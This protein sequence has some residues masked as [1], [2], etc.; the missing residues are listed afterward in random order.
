ML[1]NLHIINYRNIQQAD[2]E[3][4]GGINCFVGAN[5][6]GKTNLLDAVYY[7]SFTKSAFCLVDSQ[8]IYHGEPFFVLQG[9][10]NIDDD[11]HTIY[12]GCKRGAKKQFKLDKVDYKRLAE[13]IGYQ[14]LVIISPSD[15]M[16]IAEGPDA[17]RKYADSVISQCNKRY[18]D[19]L[20][21]YNQLLQQRN[22]L[23]KQMQEQENNNFD[24]LDVFDTQMATLGNIITE[25]RRNF[26]NWLQPIVCKYYNQIAD[27]QESVDMNY[28]SC[29]DRYSLYEG[30]VQSRQ[31]DV[32]LGYTSRGVH[33]D[34]IDF[35][36]DGFSIKNVGSQGQRKSFVISLKLAQYQY[37]SEHN[38]HYPL[39]LLDDIFDKLDEH[40]GNRLISLVAENNF[41]Q[42]F[43][44]DT[45]R[46]RLMNV[47]NKVGKDFRIFSVNNGKVTTE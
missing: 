37:I 36:L 19:A 11:E 5:G 6:A 16:L 7:L 31:R 39:L 10:Y 38:K 27:A 45:N 29:T 12:C 32:I 40:R 43:I 47:L 15:E 18:L 34:D 3:M 8:N 17:R 25:A 46:N 33:K 21:Q 13:H 30:F 42:I 9:T 2:L 41:E 14:P 26:V 4:C 44:S 20:M 23:L 22:T 24:L 1:K 28:I 35:L